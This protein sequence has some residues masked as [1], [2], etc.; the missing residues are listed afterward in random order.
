MRCVCGGD[1]IY[2][3]YETSTSVTG[4]TGKGGGGAGSYLIHSL[5]S[6]FLHGVEG[7]R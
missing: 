7:V 1:K 2:L 3:A 5:I 6:C 4:Y